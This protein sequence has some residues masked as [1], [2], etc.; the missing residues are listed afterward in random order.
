MEKTHLA[1]AAGYVT[2]SDGKVLLVKSPRRG[3]EYPGGMIEPGEDILSALLREIYEESGVTARVTGFAGMNKNL[4]TDGI[5]LDFRCEY[6]SGGLRTSDEST[7]VGWFTP[8]ECERMITFPITKVRFDRMRNGK[9]TGVL[10]YSR[11]SDGGFEIRSNDE[12]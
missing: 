1:S 7:E 11:T 8:D 5:H 3:W 9:K 12:I 4:T 6:V 2:R 10:S